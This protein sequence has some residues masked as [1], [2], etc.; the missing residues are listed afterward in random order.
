MNSFAFFDE[1]SKLAWPS[2]VQ[3]AKVQQKVD[4]HFSATAGPGRWDQFLKNIRSQ[5]YVDRLGKHPGA[6]SELLQHAQAMHDLSRGNTVGKVY[7]A[8]LPG[9]SYEIK[10]L[11]D[12]SLGCTCGDWRFRGSLSP[13][14]ACKHIRAHRAGQK[15]AS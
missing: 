3:N 4:S 6:D 13:G 5:A 10:G 12:G 9:K 8:R 7:S 14:Y 1:L 2:R 15:R 11:P